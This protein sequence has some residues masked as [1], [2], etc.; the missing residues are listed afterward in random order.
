M[1]D[2]LIVVFGASG[3]GKVVC[4]I[5]R[6]LKISVA[7]FVDSD[8]KFANREVM[9]LPVLGDENWFAEKA[10][11]STVSVALG[12]GD[13][14]KRKAAAERC[15]DFGM[16]VITAVH[17]SAVVAPS[18]KL[19]AGTTVMAGAIINP[20]AEIGR[21]VIINTGAIIEHDVT[22]GDFSH[23]S[24]GAV[25]GGA[26]RIGSLSHVGLGAIILPR[27]VVG[28]SVIIGAGSVVL[29]DVPDNVVAYGV[30]AKVQSKVA[31]CVG[32]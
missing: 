20:D 32:S 30:P 21:G 18:A 12:M 24:P 19:G 4:D 2:S 14:R 1:P 31:T 13:Q 17:P 10:K 22:I 23:V 5:L 3:H 8:P 15:K 11:T 29:H 26:A 16:E 6:A 27:V 7:G 28:S 9:G 25:T